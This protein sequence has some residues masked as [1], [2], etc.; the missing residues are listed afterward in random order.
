MASF[1]QKYSQ[2]HFVCYRRDDNHQQ[3]TIETDSHATN[4]WNIPSPCSVSS[5]DSYTASSQTPRNML[6]TD[7]LNMCTA[8]E[9]LCAS[10]SKQDDHSRGCV[11]SALFP[12]ERLMDQ[13]SVKVREDFETLM[14]ECQKVCQ[15]CVS[16]LFNIFY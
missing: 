2:S 10:Q 13:L 6:Q 3:S 5:L 14:T 8:V 15:Y 1:R 11:R 16:I 12:S 7:G 4:L 9:N